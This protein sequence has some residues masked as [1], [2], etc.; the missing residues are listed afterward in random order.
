MICFGTHNRFGDYSTYIH[1][2]R[3]SS[4]IQLFRLF[5]NL[6]RYCSAF[7]AS[8]C[9]LFLLL[10]LVPSLQGEEPGCLLLPSVKHTC[11]IYY[12]IYSIP[13]SFSDDAL[14][15]Y[16][17]YLLTC[18]ENTH[19]METTKKIKAA[20][21]SSACNYI[22]PI[23]CENTILKGQCHNKLKEPSDF[24]FLRLYKKM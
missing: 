1:I 2:K 13:R 5:A 8:S 6:V 3:N 10:L 9:F 24:G 4:K 14:G 19:T 23:V 21:E 17:N 18:T 7:L 20:N 16:I 11:D 12:S 15:D 22:V